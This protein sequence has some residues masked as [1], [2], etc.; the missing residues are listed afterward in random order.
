MPHRV[1]LRA[2]LGF[3]DRRAHLRGRCALCLLLELLA[4]RWS[5]WWLR[6]VE[7]PATRAVAASTSA[8]SSAL[9]TATCTYAGWCALCLV[10]ELCVLWWQWRV[11]DKW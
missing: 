5:W 1:D 10:H 4:L 6:D 9:T 8:P 3:G 7:L 11:H 2:L